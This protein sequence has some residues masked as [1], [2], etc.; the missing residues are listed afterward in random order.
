MGS[1]KHARSTSSARTKAPTP[2]GPP[3]V[4]IGGVIVVAA[5]G[6]VTFYSSTSSLETS[7]PPSAP[8]ATVSDTSI[9]ASAAAPATDPAT[10]PVETASTA[11]A[12]QT[13]VPDAEQPLPPLP[14][15]PNMVPRPLNVVRDAYTFAARH[16]DILE[17]VP[18]FCGCETA[19][20]EANADCFV[21][22]RNVDGSVKDWDTHGMGCAVC[23]D[24]ARDSAQL[25]RSGA[26]VRDVR[27]AIDAKYESRFPRKTPTPQPQ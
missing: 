21:Q 14:V 24:V 2:A 27:A 26:S 17:F 19:G 22:S 20:H 10:T 12:R 9:P 18:C 15:V 25:R 5:L 6:A 1:K 16:P 7:G 13:P 4:L 23:I 8:L 3:W 11:P